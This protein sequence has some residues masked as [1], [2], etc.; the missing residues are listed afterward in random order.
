MVNLPLQATQGRRTRQATLH[1]LK[2]FE[3]EPSLMRSGVVAV[4]H[5]HDLCAA[6][7]FLIIK[8]AAA[9]IEHMVGSHRLP[10]SYRKVSNRLCW[11]PQLFDADGSKAGGGDTLLLAHHT[12]ANFGCS[13]MVGYRCLMTCVP[14]PG[15]S[16]SDW[17]S[18]LASSFDAA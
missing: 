9:V 12:V 11:M 2:R 18:L 7:G 16:A 4:E 3:F 6:H 8:G 15:L 13:S 1:I 14:A 10:P 17:S 5:H